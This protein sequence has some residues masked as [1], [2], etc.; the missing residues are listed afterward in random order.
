MKKA[1]VDRAVELLA[2]AWQI[3]N[4]LPALPEECRPK[5][6]KDG[7]QVQDALVRQLGIEV[8]G[9][10]IGCTSEY[11]QKLLKTK[12][13]FAGRVLAPRI[14]ASGITLPGSAYRMRGLEGEFAFVLGKDLKPRKRPY[15]RSE[16]RA[17]VVEVRPAIEL[18]DSRFADWM[19]VSTPCLIADLACNA[20]LVVGPPMKRWKTIDLTKAAVRMKVDGKVVGE[21]KG[22]DALGDPFLALAWLANELRTREGLKAGQIVST[23][24]CTGFHKAEPAAKVEADF[25][26][27]GKVS[28]TLIKVG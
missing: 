7:M 19:S 1:G 16:V 11:A 18:V 22:A 3:G 5:T 21:G 13:P 17:A 8:G 6:A 27:L 20:A 2:D 25:G 28:F 9:W 23:G 12:G 15:T 10:K 26:N 24:T 4:A 14:F